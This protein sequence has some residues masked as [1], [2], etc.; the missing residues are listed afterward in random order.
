MEF[1]Y[2][3][4][5]LIDPRSN[6]PFYVGKG[7]GNRCYDHLRESETVNDKKQAMIKE[8]RES[9]NE[10]DVVIINDKLPEIIALKIEGFLINSIKGL[11][12]IATPKNFAKVVGDFKIEEVARHEQ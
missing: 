12:N 11:T 1:E 2:Y 7:K 6:K 3:V 5:L 10:V 4:Y 9:G 8:I